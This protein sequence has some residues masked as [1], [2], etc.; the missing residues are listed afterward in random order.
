MDAATD[1]PAV[2]R[3]RRSNRLLSPAAWPLE[4]RIPLA[5]GLVLATL[6]AAFGFVGLSA[7]EDSRQHALDERRI[8]ARAAA[9]HIDQYLQQAVDTLERVAASPAMTAGDSNLEAES[10]AL[11]AAYLH[12]GLFRKTLFM[13]DE[14]GTVLWT[15]PVDSRV[16]L[17]SNVSQR[18]TLSTALL[19]R[20]PVVSGSECTIVV[21]ESVACVT[22]PVVDQRGQVRAVIGGVLDLEEANIGG[23]LSALKL[24]QTGYAQ[25]VDEDGTVLASTDVTGRFHREEHGE[26]FAR[27]IAEQRE[28]VGSCHACHDEGDQSS[29]R[30]DVLAFAPLA[31]APW[32]VAVGQSEDEAFGPTQ[33]L[34]ERLLVLALLSVGFALLL[35]WMGI[36]S[37]TRP[38]V[39][40]THAA[41]QIAS[42]DLS[43]SA[44]VERQDEIGRLGRSFEAMRVRLN[45]SLGEIQGWNRDLEKRVAERTTELERSREE[46]ARLYVELQRKERAR[47]E[48]LDKVMTAQEEERKR[49]AR[50]LHDETSQALSALVFAAEATT[51]HLGDC[52]T[53][54][55]K[56]EKMRELALGTLDEVHR[57]IFDLRPTL[58]D[59]LGLAAALRWY[60]ESRLGESGVRVHL[61]VVGKE[62]RLRP[63]VE[64]AV[65]RTIQEAITNVARHAEASSVS[66]SLEFRERE[67]V[68]EVEDDGK[69]FNLIDADV[70]DGVQGL[71]LLGMRERMALVGGELD[72]RSAPGA[73]TRVVLRV[74]LKE[75]GS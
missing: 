19:E 8:I 5:V 53:V 25:V 43:G 2:A 63:G 29:R 56:L 66:V 65:Y 69:G 70:P 52:T 58:L 44:H 28:T 57:L 51:R 23:F 37:F 39:A 64:T 42:G 50:E 59:D 10:Q 36:R 15:E 67:L 62:L 13:A 35:A 74:P 33:T 17:G 31:L 14:R 16:Q 60:A 7:V 73:G 61:D 49:I 4:A 71:G 38:L 45:A 20:R 22:V 24:G 55:A 6:L 30:R 9:G 1:H 72:V 26:R 27:L 11:D 48:L 75:G 46:T 18:R 40:L 32:G 34:R 54:G 3:S 47:T 12:T 41:E 68:A 21:R